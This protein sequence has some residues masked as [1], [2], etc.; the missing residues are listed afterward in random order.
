MMRALK[1]LIQNQLKRSKLIEPNAGF[2]LIELLVAMILAVLVIAP[3]MSFM[4]SVMNTDRQEQAKATT[5]QEIQAAL[6]YIARDL[7]QAVYI[8]DADGLTRDRNTTTIASSGIRDQIPPVKSAPN[9]APTTSASPS[10]CTPILVFWKR[11]FVP[12][13]VGVTSTSDTARDDGFAYSLVAY[14][15]ITNP[16]GTNAN[17]T[18]SPSARIGRFELRGAVNAENSNVSAQTGFNPPPLTNSVGG[19]TLKE[20]MN[21][22]QSALTGTQTYDQRVETLVD[23]I[24]TSTTA[25]AATCSSGQRVGNN[26]SG[27]VSGFYA[28]VDAAQVVAQV[29]LRGNALVRLHN[30]DNI[31]F[32]N[33]LST[34]FPTASIRVQGRG[35]LFTQ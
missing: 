11:Q 7:Q 17:T 15:L 19:S 18:W 29:Y 4:I 23:F 9:C 31:T 26:T 25:P 2:S 12:N 13:S 14:Y 34:Y 35:F 28:C 5:E 16:N 27:N 1:F 21:Q 20:K 32:A 33:N 30:R 8:Y 10:V 6:D 24:S 3:L 22:W